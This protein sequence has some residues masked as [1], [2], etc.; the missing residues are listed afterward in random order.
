MGGA[1]P[2]QHDVVEQQVVEEIPCR[3]GYG[4]ADTDNAHRTFMQAKQSAA[5]G[6]DNG[7]GHQF[8]QQHMTQAVGTGTQAVA[9]FFCRSRSGG[10]RFHG[11]LTPFR[12]D[13]GATYLFLWVY[14]DRNHLENR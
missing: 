14:K 6:N 4:A 8:E 3:G 2:A 5:T 9:G 1:V 13:M 11:V 12:V 10:G 7:Q